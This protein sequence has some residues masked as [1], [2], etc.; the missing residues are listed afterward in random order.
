MTVTKD[1][2]SK[3][4]V[5]WVCSLF[6]TIYT[7]KYLNKIKGNCCDNPEW[8]DALLDSNGNPYI[9]CENCGAMCFD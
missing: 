1:N 2:K 6:P 9:E 7:R 8:N 5:G 4:I 3:P